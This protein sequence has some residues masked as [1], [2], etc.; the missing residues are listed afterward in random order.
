MLSVAFC[1]L[2]SFMRKMRSNRSSPV[3][4][5]A[6]EGAAAMTMAQ[7]VEIMRSLQATVEASRIEQA[8]MHE[9]LA[10]SRARNDEL[11]GGPHRRRE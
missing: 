8:R 7:M 6:A 11:S 10:A 3:A 5:V 1:D 9:D 2:S 4:P